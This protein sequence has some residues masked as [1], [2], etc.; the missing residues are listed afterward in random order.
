MAKIQD[1]ITAQNKLAKQ[2]KEVFPNFAS[3]PEEKRHIVY[4]KSQLQRL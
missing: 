4:A 1:V 3:K 2:I